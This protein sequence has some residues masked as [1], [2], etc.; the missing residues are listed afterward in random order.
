LT[1]TLLIS[2]F[3]NILARCR[4][5]IL[6]APIFGLAVFAHSASPSAHTIEASAEQFQYNCQLTNDQ[7]PGIRTVYLRHTFNSGSTASRF[8]V[9][10]SPGVTMTYVSETHSFATTLGDSQSGLSICYGACLPGDVI[11][12]SISYLS[13]GTD[14]N[15]SR[16]LVVPH[17]LTETVEVLTCN[18]TP[19]AA[20]VRDLHV[21][22]PGGAPC[23]C[24]SGHGFAGEA[25]QFGCTA[26]PVAVTTWG[27]VKALY[28]N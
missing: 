24:P 26:L 19:V 20:F 11:L 3:R 28:Q 10:S 2:R 27:K 25:H 14:E 23:G 17:P 8:R 12:G 15:C 1:G 22:A 13:S 21:I 18:A 16:V 9:T 5:A 6:A 7:G 4:A